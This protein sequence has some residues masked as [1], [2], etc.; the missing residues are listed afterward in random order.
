MEFNNIA[1]SEEY[2]EYRKK[3]DY[4]FDKKYQENDVKTRLVGED[5]H[6]LI[7]FYYSDSSNDKLKYNVH[8]SRTEIFDSEQKK[9]SE[10]RNIDHHVDFFSFIKHSNGKSYLFFSIDLY[11]YS[12]MDLS[13]YNVYHYV[14]EES[15]KYGQETFIWTEV[16][17]CKENN[18]VAVDGCYWAHPYSTE[19]FDILHPTKLPFN[20][21]CSSN[22]LDHI[23]N[24][25]DEVIPLRWN[26]DGTIVLLCFE[27]EEATT[28]IEKTIDIISLKEKL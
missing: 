17:Y 26:D 16:H 18:I 22:D 21:I 28:Q 8:A 9:V 15:F 19:F 7:T 11:G 6:T 12:I 20:K 13:N 27:D 23:C 10:L 14:P 1:Y 25:D 2:K 24:V 5:G 3:L 4:I